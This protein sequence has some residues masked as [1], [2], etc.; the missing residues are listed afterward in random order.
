MHGQL[1]E[2]NKEKMAIFS[3]KIKETFVLANISV[4]SE[5]G[6]EYIF[7]E[8]KRVDIAPENFKLIVPK[9]GLKGYES[10]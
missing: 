3:E 6:N 8:G 4:I 2:F 9:G 10:H 5:K 1:K 7:V